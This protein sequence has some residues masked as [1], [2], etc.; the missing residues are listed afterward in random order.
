MS[1][2]SVQQLVKNYGRGI[3]AL[4]GVTLQV[5]EGQI[6]G[7]IGPNGAG[8][9]TLVKILL[10]IVHKTSGHA[11]LLGRPAGEVAVRYQVG[12]LPEDHQLPG[13]HTGWSLLDYYGQLYGLSRKER[14]QRIPQIL[15]Q[16]G[17]LSRSR[18]KIRTYSKGMKQ[19]LGL[20]QALLHRPKVIFLDEPTDGVDPVGRREIREIMVQLRRE[21]HTIFLNSHLLGE[22]EQICDRVAILR[23]GEVVR[24]GTVP[25]LTRLQGCFEVGLAAGEPFPLEEAQ[26]LGYTVRP[27][28]QPASPPGGTPLPACWEVHLSD[29][30]SIDPLLALLAEKQLHLRHLVERRLS[31]EDVFIG[32]QTPQAPPAQP[33]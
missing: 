25:E 10:G 27:L 23:H 6:Y 33:S 32:L 26:R 18:S 2:V 20:A 11:E 7:L 5:E 13:Y 24:E 19:R 15:E 1:V 14:Q 21:G 16:V 31:L 28:A 29:G 8:K 4:R 30:Q 17:L 22:V 3:L 9:T 12:Y